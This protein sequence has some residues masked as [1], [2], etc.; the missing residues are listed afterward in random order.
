MLTACRIAW[1]TT[2]QDSS[3]VGHLA[4]GVQVRAPILGARPIRAKQPSGL[5]TERLRRLAECF[6]HSFVSRLDL[7]VRRQRL[8]AETPGTASETFLHDLSQVIGAHVID[9]VAVR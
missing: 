9:V 8:R 7:R 1:D 6:G 2:A 4:K 3:D 5:R